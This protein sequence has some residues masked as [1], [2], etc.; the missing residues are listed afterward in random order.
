MPESQSAWVGMLVGYPLSCA[1]VGL[2]THR[3]NLHYNPKAIAMA[4]S[5]VSTNLCASS[6]RALGPPRSLNLHATS[7]S[8]TRAV[9]LS[10]TTG[11]RFRRRRATCASVAWAAPSPPYSARPCSRTNERFVSRAVLRRKTCVEPPMRRTN[12]GT[13]KA[14]VLKREAGGLGVGRICKQRQ[15][16]RAR[17]FAAGGIGGEMREE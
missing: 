17:V 9:C 10:R 3:V 2:V 4:G 11:S 7:R 6:P 12:A 1:V 16:Q 15:R 5:A 8:L 14:A 13:E